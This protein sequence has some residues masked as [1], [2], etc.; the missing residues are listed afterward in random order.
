MQGGVGRPKW[1]QSVYE[2][3][4]GWN[5]LQGILFAPLAN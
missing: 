1:Q 2:N 4:T 5:A 3:K